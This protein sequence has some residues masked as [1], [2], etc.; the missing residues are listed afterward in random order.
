LKAPRGTLTR[1]TSDRVRE[2]IFALLG[3]VGDASVLDLFA[4]TGGLGIE[5]ISRGAAGAVFIERDRRAVRVLKE[6]LDSLGVA[7]ARAQVRG[8]EVLAALR[9]ARGLAETYDLVFIDPPYSR[10]SDL[11]REL[12]R[13][14]PSLLKPEARI[15]VESDRRAPLELR[16]CLEQERMYGDTLIRI[17]RQP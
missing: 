6:N 12:S 8:V 15:V 9:T 13:L 7:P 16:A 11:G 10:A 5:A 3:D 14:L 2:A 17:H 1:P 4:G